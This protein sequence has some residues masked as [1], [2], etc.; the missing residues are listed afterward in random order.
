[1]IQQPIKTPDYDGICCHCGEFLLANKVEILY[2]Q[3]EE[4][5]PEGSPNCEY[6]SRCQCFKCNR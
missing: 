2:I 6:D 5:C 3:G 1:M 4:Y